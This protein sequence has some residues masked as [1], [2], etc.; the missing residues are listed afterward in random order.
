VAY[1]AF[2]SYSH[3]AD[4]KLA[5]AVRSALHRFA[6]PWYRLRALRVFCDT[7]SLSANPALWPAIEAAL[8]ESDWLL[9]MAS[10]QSAQSRWV[11]MEV[12]WWLAHRSPER[13]LILFTEGEICWDPVAAAFDWT[14]TTA[15]PA[16]L[17]GRVSHEPLYVDLRWTRQEGMLSLRLPRFRAAV[18]DVAAPLHGRSK[19]ELAGEDV[20][21]HRITRALASVGVG[22]ILCFAAL[23][24]WQWRVAAQQRD[25]ARR[26]EGIAKDERATAERERD[27]ARLAALAEQAA[28]ED[29]ARQREEAERQRDAANDRLARLY[30]TNGRRASGRV[31]SPPPS[32]SIAALDRDQ[33]T[34]TVNGPTVC[35]SARCCGTS[36]PLATFGSMTSRSILRSSAPMAAGSSSPPDSRTRAAPA[37]ARP[38]YGT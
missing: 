5:Q 32:W 36:L 19:D 14:R 15:L 4:A 18:L 24:G 20:R 12:D 11:Q 31:T 33:A 9:L 27:R 3:A 30:V 17:K 23:A 22:A 16:T 28:K 37:P 29:E 38:R 10:P 1:R 2:I 35:A 6:K 8:Q 26:Q 7:T 13:M 34:A 21:Q 25:E